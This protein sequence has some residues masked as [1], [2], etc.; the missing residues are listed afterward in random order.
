MEQMIVDVYD[1]TEDIFSEDEYV[2]HMRFTFDDF[3]MALN[4]IESVV[5]ENGKAVV[6]SLDGNN[7]V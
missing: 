2:D 6:V 7:H 5:S 1:S 4:F 3:H